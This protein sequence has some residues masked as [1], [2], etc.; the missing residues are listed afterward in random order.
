MTKYVG[1]YIKEGGALNQVHDPRLEDLELA[2]ERLQREGNASVPRLRLH[3]GR[4]SAPAERRDDSVCGADDDSSFEAGQTWVDGELLGSPPEWASQMSS[5]RPESARG[6]GRLMH[7]DSGDGRHQGMT[8]LSPYQGL[9][10]HMQGAYLTFPEYSFGGCRPIKGSPERGAPFE[11]YGHKE[12]PASA[13]QQFYLR[14]DR[15]VV[16]AM[17]QLVEKQQQQQQQ[18]EINLGGG[19]GGGIQAEKPQGQTR[20]ASPPRVLPN[21]IPVSRIELQRN[22]QEQS[23]ARAAGTYRKVRGA[24]LHLPSCKAT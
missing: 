8:G 1:Q 11:R 21:G 16:I 2:A 24:F 10:T 4:T 18:Q 7:Q 13:V 22:V 20:Q 23:R 9:A 17:Q 6:H 19:G 12:E 14:P 5:S 3:S 15:S